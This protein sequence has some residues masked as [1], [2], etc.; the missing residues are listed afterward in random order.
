MEDMV[1]CWCV[2]TMNT[3]D[4]SDDEYHTIWYCKEMYEV[5]DALKRIA[6]RLNKRTGEFELEVYWTEISEQEYYLHKYEM[7]DTSRHKAH[8]PNGKYRKSSTK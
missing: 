2:H 3:R 7:R 5:R 8:K 4:Q 6:S 1:E